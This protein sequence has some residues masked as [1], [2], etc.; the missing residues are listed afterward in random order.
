MKILRSEKDYYNALVRIE[1]LIDIDPEKGSKLFDE[2]EVLSLLISKYE[3]EHYP[4]EAPAPVEA[5]K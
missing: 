5:K 4:I 3:D 2:L 1:E